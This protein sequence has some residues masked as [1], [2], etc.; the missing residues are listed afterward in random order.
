VSTPLTEKICP[1]TLSVNV[2]IHTTGLKIHTA[3]HMN[4]G[5]SVWLQVLIPLFTYQG[6]LCKC[7]VLWLSVVGDAICVCRAVGVCIYS[8]LSDRFLAGS[9]GTDTG[10][11]GWLWALSGVANNPQN[12][13]FT[14][15][16]ASKP[17]QNNSKTNSS[18]FVQQL[19]R[20]VNEPATPD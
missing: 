1:L 11:C 6:R 5:K 8:D 16:C 15:Q 3:H 14:F 17:G 4:V 2:C 9:L 10:L 12:G 19:F 7:V 13:M 20:Q 18:L